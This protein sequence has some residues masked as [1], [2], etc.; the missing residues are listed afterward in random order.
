[1]PDLY[2]RDVAKELEGK[3]VYVY[4]RFSSLAQK[5][6]HSAKRQNRRLPDFC[7]EYK[8]TL[9]ESLT[10]VDEGKS[11]KTG[12]HTKEGGALG[13]FLDLVG[14]GA[15][16]KGS[17]FYIENWD[18]FGRQPLSIM[19]GYANTILKSGVRIYIASL[20]HRLYDQ[21]SPD[22][23]IE[24]AEMGAEFARA[25]A[26]SVRKQVFG[27]ENW[28][29]YRQRTLRGEFVQ[30]HPPFWLR[31]RREKGKRVGYEI[32]EERAVVIR[33]IFD[34]CL[35]GMGQQLIAQTLSDEQIETFTGGDIWEPS[36]INKLLKNRCLVGEL[37][38]YSTIKT[39]KK[40]FVNIGKR[41]PIGEPIKN[42]YPVIITEEIFDRAQAALADRCI[43]KSRGR[44]SHGCVNLLHGLIESAIDGS[45]MHI[46]DKGLG[47]H[48]ASSKSPVKTKR[49][50]YTPYAL[51]EQAFLALADD[52]PLPTIAPTGLDETLNEIELIK[53]RLIK[54]KRAVEVAQKAY[55]DDA[56]ED[57]LNLLMRCQTNVKTLIKQLESLEQSIASGPE[58]ALKSTKELVVQLRS[59]SAEETGVI[60]RKIA[61]AIRRWVSKVVLLPLR[62]G[63]KK[64]FKATVVLV[65]GRTIEISNCA[66]TSYVW[67]E[68][69][70]DL[71]AIDYRK[72][73]KGSRKVDWESM[74]ETDRQ[75]LALLDK[76]KRGPDIS[77]ELGISSQDLSRILVRHG[78]RL[79]K[80][81][82]KYT[83]ERQMSWLGR[84]GVW[85]RKLD[86]EPYRV[87][88][89]TLRKLYPK[90]VT[91]DDEKGSQ[92][93]A[94][95]WWNDQQ[96]KQAKLG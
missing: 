72:W 87:N 9:N 26:E 59:C 94:T 68:E 52:L 22:N 62:L 16:P 53:G 19:R 28:L 90:L 69:L 75:V 25:H 93:A 49:T 55:D 35:A 31:V 54:A 23:P 2:D 83:P 92:K 47:R 44:I 85:V 58:L 71:V 30:G 95:R 86:G 50:H 56:N 10:F 24:D 21:T 81:R 41:V 13:Y 66:D 46:G 18:R 33:R 4:T 77:R 64:A 57:V 29:E 89:T 67:P 3:Q 51:I 80:P 7:R 11:G 42:Y 32:I 82:V 8:C 63:R 79:T 76:G 48:I 39:E 88:V 36:T 96:K 84:N 27:S 65:N 40:Q 12:A 61:S 15:I 34:L 17:I 73:P 1:M 38:Y 60:R 78:K 37:Q 45:S 74:N 20:P 43:P 6:G 91:G 14:A 70:E 5:Q